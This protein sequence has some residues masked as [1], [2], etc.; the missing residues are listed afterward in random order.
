MRKHVPQFAPFVDRTGSLRRA[1]T[2]DAARKRELLEELAQATFIFALLGIDLG[3]RPLEVSWTQDAGRAMPRS[4]HENHVQVKLFDQPVQVDVDE[5]KAGARSPMSEQAVL[6]L[7]RLQS[8]PQQRI[9]LEVNHA[10]RQVLARP[11]V[12]VDLP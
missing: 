10:E 8:F 6:D 3:V 4:R 12:G 5:S 11:P 9:V 7:L 2:A 1:V